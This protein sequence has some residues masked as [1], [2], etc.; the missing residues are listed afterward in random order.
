MKRIRLGILLIVV[1]WL[2]I[3]QLILTIAHH[4]HHLTD[5]HQSQVLRLIIWGLQIIIGLIGLWL[6]GKLAA[7]A[8]RTDGWKHVPR[9]MWQLFKAG[10]ADN[11]SGL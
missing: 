5:D 6:V 2:P 8:A 4:Y 1:S 7:E 3:A 11:D 10:P 9:N